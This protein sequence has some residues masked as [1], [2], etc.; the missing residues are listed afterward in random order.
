[1]ALHPSTIVMALLT[2][3]PF[4]LAVKDTITGTGSLDVPRGEVP[5]EEASAESS[6]RAIREYEEQRDADA[7]KLR[8]AIEKLIPAE[9]GVIALPGYELGRALPDSSPDREQLEAMRT[10]VTP[11]T[12][13]GTLKS[14]TIAFPQQR[15]NEAV[16]ELVS[17]RLD[18]WGTPSRTYLDG[19]SRR[20][21]TTTEPHQRVTFVEPEGTGRCELVIENF[22]DVPSF[23]T[24]TEESVIPLWAVGKSDTKLVGHL[25]AN[26]FA[27]ARQIRWTELGVGEGLG[28]TELHA[29]VVKGKIVTITAKFQASEATIGALVEKLSADFGEPTETDPVMWKKAKLFIATLDDTAGTYQLVVG[30]PLPEEE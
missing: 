9:K 3:I 5:E 24:K 27:D 19:A 4:G 23:I 16:C 29:R 18:E 1:M 13:D 7:A 26:A 25:G 10:D 22:V 6:N 15:S 2:A 17:Q 8:A 20:H 30:A 28:E 12:S 11:V 21:Y 14:L